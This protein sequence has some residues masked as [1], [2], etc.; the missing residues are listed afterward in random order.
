VGVVSGF[1]PTKKRGITGNK[2]LNGSQFVK[3]DFGGGSPDEETAQNKQRGVKALRSTLSS[4]A[5][6]EVA[7]HGLFK[8]KLGKRK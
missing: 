6:E 7:Y 4:T 8:A 3:M 2:A 5:A 1:C